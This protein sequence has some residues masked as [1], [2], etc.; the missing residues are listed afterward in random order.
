MFDDHRLRIEA[1][2]TRAF[3]GVDGQRKVDLRK[4]LAFSRIRTIEGEKS[5]YFEIVAATDVEA[6]DMRGVD[7][8]TTNLPDKAIIKLK[9]RVHEGILSGRP[10]D[11]FTLAHEFGHVVFCHPKE[12]LARTTRTADYTP[13]SARISKYERE[14]NRFASF[15][16]VDEQL[17]D[18]CTSSEALARCFGVSL[19]FAERWF[20]ERPSGETRARISG[21]FQDLLRSLET[22]FDPARTVGVSVHPRIPTGGLAMS[23]RREQSGRLRCYCTHGTLIPTLSGKLQCD[24]CGRVTEIPDGD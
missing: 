22:R 21:G 14:A 19:A 23:P 24:A 3:F 1:S 7:A 2:R 16:L 17:A 12:A 4:C 6:S 18:D 9:S 8:L 5:L 20:A 15:F 10:G 11:G 13:I